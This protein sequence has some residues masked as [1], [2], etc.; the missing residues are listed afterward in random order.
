MPLEMAATT[1]CRA[2]P[3][4][5]GNE[6]VGLMALFAFTFPGLTGHRLEEDPADDSERLVPGAA[7][8]RISKPEVAV[9]VQR[10]AQPRCRAG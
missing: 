9:F 3:F 10:H 8:G 4:V 7:T 1:W 6:R 5:D 2:T